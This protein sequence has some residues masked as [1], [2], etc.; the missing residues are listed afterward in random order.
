MLIYTVKSGRNEE[1]EESNDSSLFIRVVLKMFCQVEH[2]KIED[3]I[4][5]WIFYPAIESRLFVNDFERAKTSRSLHPKFGKYRIK[6][7]VL[8]H[9]FHFHFT[10]LR[11][12]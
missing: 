11:T 3:G 6:L 8:H 7:Y 2:D 12:F 5:S 4:F 1:G 10:K 9:I